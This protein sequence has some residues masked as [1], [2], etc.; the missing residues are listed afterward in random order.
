MI[1]LNHEL[2]PDDAPIAATSAGTLL[3]WGVFTTIGVW[4]QRPFVL[5]LHL[6]RLRHDAAKAQIEYSIADETLAQ[7]VQDVLAA[8]DIARGLARITVTQRGDHRWNRSSG[9]D[10]S[11]VAQKL[12]SS[13]RLDGLRISLSPFRLY[14]QR[15]T[16]GIKT[17]SYLDHQMAWME[18]QS[19]G[20]DE[21]LLRNERDE[22]CEGARSNI[23]WVRDRTLCTPH[24]STGCL[25]GIARALL[26]KW[27]A[28]EGIETR[29]DRFVLDDLVAADEVFLSSASVGPRCVC[30]VCETTKLLAQGEVFS[31]LQ[32]RWQ[33][34][35][36]NC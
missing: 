22:I 26:L 32:K 18:A 9:S 14:S 6:Q 4:N 1:W 20:F 31:Q 34:E 5:D 29:E 10:V 3:G 35:V 17:T 16:S 24:L 25:P 28:E 7:A 30:V 36:D 12:A 11:V 21:A 8:N 2:L 19:R 13:T 33:Q 15:A 23:F 27:A